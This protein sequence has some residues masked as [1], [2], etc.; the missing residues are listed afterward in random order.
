MCGREAPV[1]LL[2]EGFPDCG[3]CIREIARAISREEL[4]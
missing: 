4:G 2:D 1:V 3:A